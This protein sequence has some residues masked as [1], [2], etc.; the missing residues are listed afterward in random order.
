MTRLLHLAVHT[1]MYIG[2]HPD[3]DHLRAIK[4]LWS[5]RMIPNYIVY[6]NQTLHL[7]TSTHGIQKESKALDDHADKCAHTNVYKHQHRSKHT[8]KIHS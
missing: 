6:K 5:N 7:T 8:L 1:L 2:I 3:Y 4:T